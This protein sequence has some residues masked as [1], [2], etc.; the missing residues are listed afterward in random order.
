MLKNYLVT[1]LRNL[2]RNRTFSLINVVGLSVGLAACML[3]FLY[4][5]DELSFDRFQRDAG[6]TYHL[7][8]EF[9][10]ADGSV[11]KETSSGLMPG[12]NF[13]REIPEI[14]DFVRLQGTDYTLRRGKDVFSQPAFFVD[15]NFFSFFSF[16]FVDGDPKTALSGPYAVVLSEDLAKKYFGK[17]RAVGRTLELEVND[18]FRPFTV[19]A[20]VKNAPANSSVPVSMML[21]IQEHPSGDDSW[22]NFFLNTFIR[23]K[24]GVD[25]KKVEGKMAGVYASDAA[26]QIKMMADKYGFKDKIVYH[27]QPLLTMHLD[28]EYVPGNG[29][30]NASNPMYS[31]ILTAIAL[32]ILVIACINFINLTVARSLKRARE[33]GIR[34]VVGGQRRQL[35]VQFLGESFVLEFIA[36]LLGIGLVKAILPFFNTVSNKALAF[37][38]LLD[39]QLVAGFVVIFVLTGL[40]AGF[41]PALVLSGF[42]P[43]ESLY[44]RKQLGGRS[45]LAKGLVVLQFTL[46]TFLI[47]AAGVIY[48]QFNYLTHFDLGYNYKN[49]VQIK[50]FGLDK[51]KLAVLKTSLLAEPGIE[52]VSMDQGGR[53]GTIAHVNG[54]QEIRFDIR[55]VDEDY[56]PLL[57]VPVVKGRNFS[58]EFV[59]DSA[60][61]VVVN[62]TFVKS[63]GW[64]QPIG[65]VVDF[66]YNHRK[67]TVVGVFKDYH[68]V[69]LNEQIPA[70]MLSMNPAYPFGDVFIRLKSGLPARPLAAIERRYKELF[71]FVPYNSTFKEEDNAA[72]YEAEKKWKQ[73]VTMGALI[74]VFVSCIGLLGLATLTAEKRRKE[75]GIRKVL[76][77]SVRLI[78]TQLSTDFVRLVLLAAV[79]ACPAA[80]WATHRW[81]QNYPYRVGVS[82]WLFVV[83]VFLVVLVALLT[84]GVQAVKAAVANPV[85]A[86]RA[87]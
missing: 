63:A 81:L 71:P 83:S 1:A 52:T 53:W 15:S 13:K 10:K 79:I 76:G 51:Q 28:T 23:L 29:L 27:L 21:P 42:R 38:Y 59:S 58:R 46:A 61:S 73:I 80:W 39:A 66:F 44:G 75:I 69:S 62:E 87:E 54:D 5:K 30:V 68:N 78:V 84:I 48:A 40:L 65:Q 47:V 50:S 19:T 25:V 77:A 82:P 18:T 33:I 70:M 55:H 60:L 24:P 64:K 6:R 57:Q 67:Y 22:L 16:P 35:I 34:K 32:F 7:V 72:Q 12:P 26:A 14:E 41:Y 49:V 9:R 3:I 20:V 31:Y 43:V 8:A 4:A 11:N 56:L 36:F 17:E 86:L 85:K 2:W 37:S 45:Y 74:T